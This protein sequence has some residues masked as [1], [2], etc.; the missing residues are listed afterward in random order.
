MS[1]QPW[2]A[3]GLRFACSACGNCCTGAPG[4]VWV[5]KAEIE[6]LAA[7]LALDVPSFTQRYIRKV[8]I[9]R[10]LVELPNNDCVFF[11]SATRKCKV[12][13][14]RPRQCRTWPFWQ[15][16]VRTREAWQY[17]CAVCPGSGRGT[18]QPVEQI[19]TQLAVIQV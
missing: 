1:D 5:N 2:Y 3:D 4:Y 15:S 7:R 19:E 13:D 9:R 17:T 16:N 6:A 18:L 14:D 12:Y 10:S 8:G 11:D